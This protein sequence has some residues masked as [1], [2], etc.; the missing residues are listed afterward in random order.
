MD[1]PLPSTPTGDT[2]FEEANDST[3]S[4]R[5]PKNDGVILAKPA[6]EKPL[7]LLIP[8][9]EAPQDAENPSTQDNQELPFK[10]NE[11]P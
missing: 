7:T 10:V 9:T 5:D 3:Q 6:V 11:N 4:E 1:D 2:I 8:S